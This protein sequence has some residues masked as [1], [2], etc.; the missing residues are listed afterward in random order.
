MEVIFHEAVAQYPHAAEAFV[1]SEENEKLGFFRGAED[2]SLVHDTG[3]A[4]VDSVLVR[5]GLGDDAAA[6]GETHGGRWV[7]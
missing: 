7:D 1:A 5:S 4:V 6:E 2:E 3:D